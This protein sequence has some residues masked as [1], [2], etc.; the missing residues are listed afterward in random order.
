[1]VTD[2]SDLKK[3]LQEEV[4]YFDHSLIYETNSLKSKTLAALTEENF[5]LRE[6]PFRPTAENFARYF[7]EKIQNK[8]YQTDSVAVYETPDNCAEYREGNVSCIL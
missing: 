4:D 2:F 1:M 7:Y 6:V 5:K 3:T 8:G